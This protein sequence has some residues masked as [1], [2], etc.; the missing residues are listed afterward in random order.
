MLVAFVGYFS[1]VLGLLILALPLLLAEL[2]RPKDAVWGA[3][4][5]VL[6]L[7]LITSNQSFDGSLILAVILNSIIIS[8]LLLEISQYRWQQ[9]DAEEKIDLTTYRR[10]KQSFSQ[11][12]SAFLNMTINLLYHFVEVWKI[13]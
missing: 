10:W 3:M 1:I 6:G 4:I 2:S 9:L 7:I 11:F 8:R 5:M 12:F 13:K